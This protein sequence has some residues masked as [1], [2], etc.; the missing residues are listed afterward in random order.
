KVAFSFLPLLHI[1]P[2]NSLC[3]SASCQDAL[4]NWTINMSLESLT[5]RC[6]RAILPKR[7]SQSTCFMPH[8]SIK[9]ISDPQ[10]I[11]PLESNHITHW[12]R[13]GGPS[14]TARGQ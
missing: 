5:L 13:K 6:R 2:V 10:A 1:Y 12:Q 3:P 9:S 11:C 14:D 8:T 4:E 7:C